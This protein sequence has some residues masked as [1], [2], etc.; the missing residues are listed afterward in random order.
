[1]PK[2]IWVRI[3]IAILLISSGGTGIYFYR[4][5][6]NPEKSA[7]KHATTGYKHLE[8]K[9]IEYAKNELLEALKTIND[10]EIK[11]KRFKANVFAGL[12]WC[13]REKE[14]WK[15]SIYYYSLTCS[16]LK[17]MLEIPEYNKNRETNLINLYICYTWIMHGCFE[18]NQ[19]SEAIKHFPE[20]EKLRIKEKPNLELA[21]I[22]M[23]M[24]KNAQKMK[25]YEFS[26][27]CCDI[28]LNVCKGGKDGDLWDIER[29]ILWIKADN[30]FQQERLPEAISLCQKALAKKLSN[31]NH[32]DDFQVFL[33]E[34][35]NEWK[36]K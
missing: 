7:K 2:K 34:K 36:K 15:T 13:Y 24:A 22:Y 8:N 12:G 17:Q 23:G 25:N 10:N 11:N 1:M 19:Y 21:K 18:T 31:H 4:Q 9:N 3:L 30:L 28:G 6:H 20:I 27:K 5:A 32:H 26:D 16:A 33:Q 14:E 35:I 29:K